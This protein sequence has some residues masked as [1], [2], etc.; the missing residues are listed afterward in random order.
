[1]FRKLC[2]ASVI[3]GALL[4]V[5][6]TASASPVWFDPHGTLP[7]EATLTSTNTGNVKFTTSL[8]TIECTSAS[9]TSSVITDSGT[10]ILNKIITWFFR[11]SETEGCTTSFLG[12]VT[13]TPKKLPW[14]FTAGGK[15]AADT[16]EIRGGECNGASSSLEVTLDSSVVG[17]CTYTKSVLSGTFTT[18]EGTTTLS[19]S[20]Q[21]FVKSAGS[22]FCPGS[23]KMD[24]LWDNYTDPKPHTA[25]YRVYII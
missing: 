24:M 2:A 4:S 20:G 13:V 14:C 25:T 3:L 1:M 22:G 11:N 6:G 7:V 18:G 19:V 5:P 23:T 10:F 9:T 21:E 8:G 15:L 17:E 12:T 16:F